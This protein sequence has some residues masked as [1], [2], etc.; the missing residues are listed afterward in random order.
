MMLQIVDCF[1]WKRETETER[2]ETER[3]GGRERERERESELSSFL[4]PS[5]EAETLL[6]FLY[7]IP[8]F[9]CLFYPLTTY[10]HSHKHIL[11]YMHTYRYC[12]YIL[13]CVLLNLTQM[14]QNRSIFSQFIFH[15]TECFWDLS[16]LT[17]LDL[18]HP[19]ESTVQIAHRPFI[20][21]LLRD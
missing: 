1:Y 13:L 2:Q 3:G 7:I 9:P 11:L 5:P 20:F 19:F 15:S 6:K 16:M 12:K 17:H 10:K 21:L 4:L 14:H 18:V 8:I